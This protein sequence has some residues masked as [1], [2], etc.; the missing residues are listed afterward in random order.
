M[1]TIL[2]DG[3]VARLLRTPVADVAPPANGAVP[4][5]TDA[6]LGH[7]EA[8]NPDGDPAGAAD[9]SELL[10]RYMPVLHFDG[11]ELF[12]PVEVDGYV[13]SCTVWDRH[14][15]VADSV[16]LRDLDHRWG[17]GTNLRFVDDNDRR[18]MLSADV[19]LTARRV[20]SPR[21]GRVGLLGRILDALF[22]LSV[23]L[24]PTCPR[25]TTAAA[26][27]KAADLELHHQ[28]VCYGRAVRAGE[29]LV[30]HYAWFYVMNDWRSSYRGLNDHEA[31]WEQ[32]WIYCDPAT[33]EPIWI[34]GSSHENRG[35]DLRRHWADAELTF[36]EGRPVLYPAAGS[37]ALFFRPGDY[38]SRIDV[39]ALRWYLRFQ[40][41]FGLGSHIS[42]QGTGPGPALGV[43][44]IDTAGG[45]GQRIAD[46]DLRVMGEGEG[47]IEGFRGLWGR[48]TGDPTQAERGPSGPKFDRS[49]EIRDSWADPLGMAGLHGTPP[50]SAVAKRVNLDKIDQTM[51]DLDAQ[52]RHRGRL[53]PLAKQTG[54][55]DQMAD[56]SRRLTRLLRQ[57]CELEGL[58]RRVMDGHLPDQGTR[59]H[60]VN[61]ATPL[62]QPLSGSWL[63]A[64]WAA[65]S[66]P[67]L[68]LVVAATLLA[69]TPGRIAL[70]PVALVTTVVIDSI[71][72][73]RFMTAARLV[74]AQVLGA[75]LI[76]FALGMVLVI[77]RYTLGLALVLGAAGLVITNAA[78]LWAIRTYRARLRSVDPS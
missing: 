55:V 73:R 53:L 9:E 8:P 48:D 77:G 41:L 68:L 10:Q 66:V 28:P 11:R 62:P 20:L 7:A 76:L 49:G 75:L 12:T 35:E 6:V 32:A 33:G 19:K 58:R 42:E 61:P 54:S 39:P 1:T 56:E 21:L 36:H 34:A 59:D 38:V 70:V 15:K 18:A 43:P 45:D 25:A 14:G 46:W 3:E 60:L 4:V 74:V 72:Q 16:E 26:A 63:Q 71:L 64:A 67:A 37:H 40:S 27:A 13:E 24:R 31:D 69:D 30:L 22:L 47:W 5:S 29:W 50:P 44:F 65:C 52:I 51:A 78:E 2:P 23:W 17:E 57:Q